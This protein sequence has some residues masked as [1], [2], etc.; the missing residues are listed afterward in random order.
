MVRE[1]PGNPTDLT[2]RSPTLTFPG[3]GHTTPRPS[4]PRRSRRHYTN[5][6]VTT[7]LSVFMPWE[8]SHAV[9]KSGSVTVLIAVKPVSKPDVTVPTNTTTVEPLSNF[10]TEIVVKLTTLCDPLFH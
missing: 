8:L 2:P 9:E 7:P 4:R 5:S 3:Y 10:V 6:M 1:G